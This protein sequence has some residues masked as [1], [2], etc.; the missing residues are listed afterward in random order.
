MPR[1]TLRLSEHSPRM[2]VGAGSIGTGIFFALEGERSLGRNESRPAKLLDVRDY[3]KLHVITDYVAVL[4][5]AA[6]SGAP[7]RVVPVGKVGDD[8]AGMRLVREMAQAGM[9]VGCVQAL[10]GQPTMLSVH[11]QY[12]DGS[13]GSITTSNSAVS[14]L[15]PEDVSSAEPILAAS[16]VASGVEAA[17]R[18]SPFRSIVLAVPGVALEARL[19]LLELG[20]R[21]GAFRV[22]VFTSTEIETARQMGMFR[23]L[24]LVALGKEEAAAILGRGFSKTEAVPFLLDLSAVLGRYNP[25][26][27]IVLSLSRMGAYAIDDW[28]WSHCPSLEVETES[29]AGAG[30]ALLAGVLSATAAGVPLVLPEAQRRTTPERA[31]SSALDFGMLLASFSATS[32]H[33]IHPDADLE[34]LLSFAGKH[35]L[36][37]AGPLATAIQA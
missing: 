37:F 11:F 17:P 1:K 9:D 20:S 35:G 15:S 16:P 7:F 10:K 23:L 2:L 25:A 34:Q 29:T 5:G 36:S 12:P 13:S 21:H 28:Q 24:D 18:Q 6:P 26:L 22:A 19:R 33:A 4:L 32:P 3:G 14:M 30:D 31:L 27:R 8:A